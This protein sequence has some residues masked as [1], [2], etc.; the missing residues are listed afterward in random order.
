MVELEQPVFGH[1]QD[2]LGGRLLLQE[3]LI[4][5]ML[6]LPHLCGFGDTL[7]QRCHTSLK[8]LD[9][10]L[11][12]LSSLLRSCNGLLQ[13]LDLVA[14]SLGLARVLECLLLAVVLL[15][16]VVR[17]L[18]FHKGGHVVDHLHDTGE[19]H[20]L[21]GQG[22]HDKVDVGPVRDGL[23][24]HLLG[25]ALQ[26]RECLAPDLRRGVLELQQARTWQSLLEEAEVFIAVQDLDRFLNGHQFLIASLLA[27][28]PLARLGFAGL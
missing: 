9:L 16:I 6:L 10:L 2:V 18:L 25:V 13:G 8:G 15:V 3:L 26:D 12:G 27:N 1:E 7:V 21:V 20:T 11:V 24:T 14:Q 23:R 4:L 22:Q 17:L 19:V 5:L 28:I